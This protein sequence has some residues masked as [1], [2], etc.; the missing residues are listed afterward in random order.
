[1]KYQVCIVALMA[2]LITHCSGNR[3][4]R[5]SAVVKPIS[6][7]VSDQVIDVGSDVFRLGYVLDE[8]SKSVI[9][10]DVLDD[11]IIDAL[12][13]DDWDQTPMPAGDQ[14]VALAL[15]DTTEP[16]RVFVADAG[17][18]VI[19]GYQL[20]QDSFAN[21]KNVFWNTLNLG[22]T[23]HRS[24]SKPLFFNKGSQSQLSLQSIE[25]MSMD[26]GIESWLVRHQGDELFEVTG[27]QIGLQNSL[28]ELSSSYTSDDDEISFIIEPGSRR[29]SNKDRFQFSTMK[30]KPLELAD[31]PVDLLIHDGVLYILTKNAAS[32]IRFDLDTLTVIDTEALALGSPLRMSYADESIWIVDGQTNQVE[33]YDIDGDAL[34]MITLTDQ[35]DAK[36][37]FVKAMDSKLYVL[38]M[39]NKSVV[40]W[41][42]DN[43]E[44]TDTIEFQFV[45]E[46]FTIF[47]QNGDE[48]ALVPLQSG[49]VEIIDISAFKRVDTEPGDDAK[50]ENLH[51]YDNGEAS[52][53]ELISVGTFNTKTKTENWQ[54]VYQGVFP[55][56]GT[57]D[58]V[59]AGAQVTFSGI[60]LGDTFVQEGDLVDIENQLYTIE[61]IDSATQITLEEVPS[62]QGDQAIMV[63]SQDSYLV[64]GSTSGLQQNRVQRDETYESDGGEIALYIRSSLNEPVTTDDFFTFSTIQGINPINPPGRS[65]AFRTVVIEKENQ[66]FP[67]AYVLYRAAG[68]IARISLKNQEVNKIVQ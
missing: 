57:Q 4:D 9:V 65:Q 40:K 60:D 39:Q 21:K 16:H 58:V 1:M 68:A 54:L 63:R 25:V 64:I 43:A 36:V 62:E 61:S 33:V 10:F 30:A 41:D 42:L 48:F 26:D 29:V 55:D 22:S 46:D 2:F 51:F 28:A 24:A 19:W 6:I 15:D 12:D 11:K 49:E 35:A 17:Q 38:D 27:A 32:L 44:T 18:K 34:S 14:P 31:E 45:P 3:S 52:S 47:E 13:G 59:V 5:R 23:T 56:L 37:H 53:P 20:A 50:F 7:I 8:Y 67:V 66:S